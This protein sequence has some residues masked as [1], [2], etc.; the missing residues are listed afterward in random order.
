MAGVE[1]GGY[2]RLAQTDDLLGEAGTH[3]DVFVAFQVDMIGQQQIGHGG[4]FVVEGREADN[5]R[6]AFQGGLN[7][8]GIG[9]VVAGIGTGHQ[10]D[11]QWIRSVA[12]DRVGQP[13]G[14]VAGLGVLSGTG[15]VD[16]RLAEAG[17]GQVVDAHIGPLDVVRFR[18]SP[19]P[20]FPVDVSGQ[21]VEGVDRGGFS[22]ASG[23]LAFTPSAQRQGSIGPGKALGQVDD[24]RGSHAGV[25]DTF[26]GCIVGQQVV[27]PVVQAGDAHRCPPCSVGHHHGGNAQRQV[28]FGAGIDRY[29]SGGLGRTVGQAGFHLDHGGFSFIFP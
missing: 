21:G 25:C 11:L 23:R 22:Q 6:D 1:L 3:G 2:H 17:C 14:Q 24:H 10:Q 15:T 20:A 4:T 18:D 12:V 27:F 9:Q 26:W 7:A 29:P 5:E 19:H 13:T 8:A 28:G 16:A